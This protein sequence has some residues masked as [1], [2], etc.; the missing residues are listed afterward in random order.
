MIGAHH[1]QH[2]QQIADVE[3]NLQT[4]EQE[5]EAAEMELQVATA[6]LNSIQQGYSAALAKSTRYETYSGA[7]STNQL[8]EA[9]A[10]AA[11]QKYAIEAFSVEQ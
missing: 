1:A 3:A 6:N 7:I 2:I 8:E 10:I 11:Q 5:R 4:A 9:R